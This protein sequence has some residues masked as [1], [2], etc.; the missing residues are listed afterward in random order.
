MDHAE[1]LEQIEIAAAEPD[2]LER[3]M[4]GDTPAASAIAGHLAGC[5]DCTAELARI[6][7]VAQLAR[8][9]IRAEPDPALRERT[10]AFV[11]AV[12]RDRST[13]PVPASAGGP[14]TVIRP[15]SI[16][17]PRPVPTA[18]AD[19]A[20]VRAPASRTVTRLRWGWLAAAAALVLVVGGTGF[21]A[22]SSRVDQAAADRAAEVQLL[23]DAVSTTVR[24]H[25]QPD[26]V[27]V[28]LAATPAAA[29]SSGSILLSAHEG[30]LVA[31]AA[32]L[33]AL[34]DGQEYGCWV[35]ASGKRLR[36]GR[37]YWA[38]GVWTW[39]G[40]VSGLDALPAGAQFGVSTG[41]EGGA[42]NSTP[43]LLGT[44]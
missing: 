36:L 17:V 42:T 21:L 8:E 10:L 40:P 22:G 44:L 4:A 30:E 37:M 27:E 43:V 14:E 34:S 15:S 12:G 25:A 5:P 33:P 20:L 32:G 2:G 16:P 28:A 29:G 6:R 26:A 1:A 7:R 9:A 18:A 13:P 19:P 31:L 38:G 3:L 11:R 39:T 41:P 24:I 35:E 23:A